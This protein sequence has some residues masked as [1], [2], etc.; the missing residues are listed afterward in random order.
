MCTDSLRSLCSTSDSGFRQDCHLVTNRIR[1]ASAALLFLG[2]LVTLTSAFNLPN[3]SPNLS[4]RLAS[5]TMATKPA[6]QRTALTLA[7][8][9]A[10]QRALEEVYWRHRIW[11]KERP[12]P[13]PSL[14]AVISQAQ[15]EKKVEDYLHNSEALEDYWKEPVTAEQLQAEMARMAQHTKQPEVLHELFEALGND[16]FVIAECLARPAL[17]ERLVTNF[18][19]HD[20]RFHGELRQRVEADLRAH[21][22]VTQMKQTS[23]NYSEIE[24]VRSDSAQDEE[25]RDAE[26]GLKM[27]S[28]EWDENIQ[29]L[30]AMFGGAKNGKARP[31]PAHPGRRSDRGWEKPTSDIKTGVLSPLQEDEERYYATAVVKKSKDRLKLATVAWRKEPF[32]SWRARAENQTPRVMA[33][34]SPNYTLPTISDSDTASGCTDNTWTVITN[35]PSAREFHTAVWTGSE[36]IVWGGYD[37]SNDV[38][39]GGRYNPGTDSWTRTSTTNAPSPRE[40]HTAVWTG[41]EMIVWGGWDESVYFNT[42]GRY[43]P[44]TDSW[45]ATSTANAPLGRI[46]HTAVWSGSEM[47]VWGGVDST[48]NDLNTGGRYNPGTDSWTAT[49]IINAPTARSGHGTVWTTSEMIVWGG[50]DGTSYLNT[51]GRY[52]PGT[53]SWTATSIINAPTARSGHGTV[54]TTSEMIAWGGYDGSNYLNTG[55]RYNPGTDSWTATSI[56]NAPTARYRYTAVW[57]G[58]EMIIWGGY[59]IGIGILNTGGRY[60]PDTDSWTATST[61]NAPDARHSHTAVWTGSEMIIWGGYSSSVGGDLDTGG[62]YNPSMNSWVA[63]STANV[64]TARDSHTAVWTGSEMIAWGGYDGTSY[65]NTGGRYNPGTDNWTATSVTNV[66][67]ARYRHTAVWTGNEM[68]IWGGSSDT[69]SFNTG[70]KYNP[71]TDSWTPTGT[72]NAPSA[73]YFHTAVWNGSEMIIWGG[74][75]DLNTGGTYN[76]ATNSWIA[77]STMNAP[78]GR[79]LHTAVWTGSKMVVWGG[80]D[81][82][83]NLNTGGKYDA[84]T[85]SWTATSTTNA[86][87]GRYQHTAVWTGSEMI[88]WGGGGNSHLFNTGGKYDPGTDS[89]SATS[90]INPPSAR[91][92]HAAVWT[93]SEMIVW[94]GVDSSN[95]LNT[96]GRYNPIMN[97]WTATTTTNAPTGRE[98][99]TAVWTGSEMIVWGGEPLSYYSGTTNTGGKYCAQMT[100]TGPPVVTTNPATNVASFSATLNGT[101]NPNGLTTSIY[102]QYGTTINYGSTTASQNYTGN[103][104]QSVSADI[105][106]LSAST[107]YHFRIVAMNTGG[108]SIGSDMTFATLSAT[109]LPVVTTNPATN[110]AS[111][112]ATLNGSLNPNGLTTSVQFQYGPTTSYGFTTPVQTQTGNTVRNI[113]ANIIG[114]SASHIYHFRIVASNSGGT[115]FGSDSTFTTLSATGPPV[116][117]TNPA[118]TVAGFSATLNGSLDPHGLTTTVHFQYGTTTSY[119]LTAAAP[120]QTGSTYRNIS[121]NISGLNASTIYHFRI[122]ATNSGGTHFGSDRTFTTLSATGAPVVTTNPATAVASFSATLNG[123]LDPHG[124]TTT[125]HF[126]YG[127]TT[128]YGLTTAVQS[129]TGNTYRNVSANIGGLSASTI[130]HVRIVATNSSGTRFGSDSTFTTLSATGPPVV[131]TNPATNVANSSATLDGSLDPH[132]LTTTVHFQYGRTTNYGFTTPSQNETGSTYRTITAHISGLSEDTIYHFRIVADNGAGNR[133]GIDRTFTTH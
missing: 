18:Y 116:V 127:T 46:A 60:N 96:G 29:K 70:G 63:T 36:M 23:G 43:N 49:S 22:S 94:G 20:Q 58:S 50:Y 93:S 69:N 47:I 4:S 74:D 54:W 89:W 37:G 92:A 52:N 128:S 115:H 61:T 76:P 126:Q 103:T 106:G 109:G 53:D 87:T 25:N 91:A 44:S 15:L 101:V 108:A 132:G 86:P 3:R 131:T 56:V 105:S 85:N 68:I 62:R 88:V 97:T 118:T 33:T 111:F 51:G 66:P 113:T 24:L 55:G 114:L 45:I 13:K 7:D 82:I 31:Q 32:E 42:G 98:G 1:N 130:Y 39:T 35:T 75:G 65:L 16:P 26:P 80:F 112:S 10:Y 30:A 83:N 90:T 6:Q 100:V 28:R 11:P 121:A 67:T 102:F 107:T 124:L 8:R 5:P 125:V 71:G 99:H 79:D 95:T 12:D 40:R 64:P 77:T 117:T 122:V 84:S 120:S 2:C 27:N 123:S 73:R 41:S 119:G 9:V 78:A 57:T 81:G 34:V 38:N 21:H 72:T 133:Y 17:S 59:A 104:T 19:A 48:F 14:D 110:V 129:Q